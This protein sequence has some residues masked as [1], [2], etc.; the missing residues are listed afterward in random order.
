MPPQV[1]SLA[2]P[3]P[4]PAAASEQRSRSRSKDRKGHAVFVSF[5]IS[6][7]HHQRQF[8]NRP[9]AFVTSQLRKRKM[10]V[11]VKKLSADELDMLDEAKENEIQQYLQN[12]AVEAIKG[13]VDLK[14]EELMGMRW[15][16]TVKHFPQKKVKARLV[17]L[18]YQAADLEDE[19]LNAATPTPTRR[20]K[21]CFLQ[22]AAHHH[23][24]LYKA[25]V[26]GAFLQGREQD[27]NRCVIPVDEL[28]DALGIHRGSPAR[29]RK[30]GYGLV[31]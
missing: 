26:S 18:G 5:E 11:S 24:E 23:F 3:A 10:E 28:A 2:D 15:V 27:A 25:D 21:Q 17:I 12:E 4:Q 16:V 1:S 14:P 19:L 13:Q 22:I 29:L 7:N 31:I 9:A 8:V 30:A 6:S 20:S